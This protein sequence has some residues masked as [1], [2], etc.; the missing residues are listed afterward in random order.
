M[1]VWFWD[2]WAGSQSHQEMTI[3]AYAKASACDLWG[4]TLKSW[5]WT[6]SWIPDLQMCHAEVGCTKE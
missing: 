6:S 3:W 4:Y 2:G 5:N 1:I